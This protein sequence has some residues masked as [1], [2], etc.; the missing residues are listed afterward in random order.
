MAKILIVED[1]RF[2]RELYHDIISG[3]GHQ[4]DTAED[5]EEAF[6]KMKQG[7]WDLVLLDIVLPKM[8]GI[9]IMKKLQI[10]PPAAPNKSLVF[11]TNLDKDQK[12]K[13]AMQYGNGYLIKSQLTPGDFINEIKLY[14][15]K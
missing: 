3:E 15:P 5:G 6:E 2:L 13:E 1:D 4:V 9:E 11:L 12:I 14:L 7:G 10:E 8:D